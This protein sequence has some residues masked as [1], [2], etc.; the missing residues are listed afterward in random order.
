MIATMRRLR[1]TLALCAALRAWGECEPWCDNPCSELSGAVAQEC[2]DCSAEHRCWPGADGF[3]GD[4]SGGGGGG[5]RH[6]KLS[7]AVDAASETGEAQSPKYV[8]DERSDPWLGSTADCQRI[9]VSAF[10]NL[11][12]AERAAL[13]EL[14][15]LVTGATEHWPTNHE[16]WLDA[17]VF[18]D[19][20]PHDLTDAQLSVREDTVNQLVKLLG[21]HYSPPSFLERASELRVLS[22]ATIAKKGV[23]PTPNHGFAWLGLLRGTMTWYVRQRYQTAAYTRFR[24]PLVLARSG[25][26]LV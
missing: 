23:H 2:G 18:D 22:V 12:V 7:I 3:V 20:N 19:V 9:G 1:L 21:R 25:Q 4:R 16:E 11:T 10:S 26:I 13:L 5:D 8:P 14:P 6:A 15:T 17:V 24:P